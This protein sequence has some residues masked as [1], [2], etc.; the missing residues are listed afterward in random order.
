MRQSLARLMKVVVYANAA[1]GAVFI[2]MAFTLNE[3]GGSPKFV[4]FEFLLAAIAFFSA[5]VV[6]NAGRLMSGEKYLNAELRKAELRKQLAAVTSSVSTII[7]RVQP[8]QPVEPPAKGTSSLAEPDLHVIATSTAQAYSH[9]AG[10]SFGSIATTGQSPDSLVANVGPVPEPALETET[11]FRPRR[12]RIGLILGSFLFCAVLLLAAIAPAKPGADIGGRIAVWFGVAL[13]AWIS[14]TLTVSALR[15]LPTLTLTARGLTLKT[16]LGTKVAEWD[17]L[18]PFEVT[19]TYFTGAFR[20]RQILFLTAQI[21]GPAVSKSLLLWRKKFVI[22]DGFTRP[23]DDILAEINLWRERA[24]YPAVAA[25]APGASD[26][27]FG[28]A[29][30]RVP[31]LTFSI[32]AVLVAVF[33]VELTY[34]VG[35]PGPKLHPTLGTLIALGGLQPM[36]VLF[37]GQWYR[38]FTAPLLHGSIPHILFNGI[39]LLM[40]GYLLE[41]LI[42]RI[43]FLAVFIIGAVGGSLLS[44]ALNPD[45]MVSVGA[46]GAIMGLFAAGFISSYRLPA[47]TAGRTRIQTQSLRVLIPSL[48]PLVTTASGG[49]IDYAAH[50]G[51][52]LAGGGVALCLISTWP[53]QHRLPRFKTLAATI[54]IAG[55][56]L[57]ATSGALVAS[58]YSHYAILSKSIPANEL[59]KTPSEIVSQAAELLARYPQDPRAH[60]Y[61]GIALE[62]KKDLVGAERE[63]R[64]ALNEVKSVP[65][66][67][68]P[69]YENSIRGILAAI[70]FDSGRLAEAKET[71][72]LVCEAPAAAQP[73]MAVIKLLA[74]RHLC[75]SIAVSGSPTYAADPNVIFGQWVQKFPNGNA[76]VTDFE[77]N[78]ME[79]YNV[80]ANGKRGTDV[81]RGKYQVTY[82]DRGQSIIGVNLS[83][84]GMIFIIVKDQ[85]TILLDFPGLGAHVLKRLNNH[86]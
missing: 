13:F 51:G 31:W 44:C 40:I 63:L 24:G 55:I 77:P 22:P 27:K 11:A 28:L 37:R 66:A 17:S 20:T 82:K 75:N 79:S 80:D 38:L 30:F 81:G 65:D 58:Q 70:I 46:S 9:V 84:G 4:A 50:L 19:K 36:D 1:V 53:E 2:A 26:N 8:P 85:D 35:P 12:K 32:L 3:R 33:A 15:G 23:L 39:A 69:K 5:Y 64:T 72:R 16:A 71:A 76:I 34:S 47:R 43:W 42:G 59:P 25:T 67:F 14:L 83:D 62:T 41:R 86:P 60:F 54:S 74:D 21:T 29:K 10:M 68:N 52:A 45:N 48:L 49:R 56:V 61:E 6:R 57:F 73:S 18:G 7:E 78:S